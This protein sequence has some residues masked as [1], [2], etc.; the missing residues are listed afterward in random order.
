MHA[1]LVPAAAGRAVA[2]NCSL[3]GSLIFSLARCEHQRMRSEFQL[4]AMV[5]FVISMSNSSPSMA[6][7]FD[8]LKLQLPERHVRSR[9]GDC[10]DALRRRENSPSLSG[11][12]ITRRAPSFCS[13]PIRG[14]LRRV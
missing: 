14:E 9:Y 8:Q 5:A 13:I 3:R 4:L 10:A 1:D 2:A 7:A 11:C 12:P 6:A